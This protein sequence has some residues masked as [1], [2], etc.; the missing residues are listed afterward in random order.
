MFHVDPLAV[1]AQHAALQFVTLAGTKIAAEL[2]SDIADDGPRTV[3]QR[4]PDST[5]AQHKIHATDIGQGEVTA[6]VDATV[7]V[8]VV[9]QYGE[10]QARG[11]EQARATAP[12]ASDKSRS[13]ETK[14]TWSEFLARK[15][16][17][18]CFQ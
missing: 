5:R 14:D 10:L 3:T 12:A 9:R 7:E 17:D 2:G 8:Q 18:V 13:G 1:S 15:D 16:G 11:I 4:D 6:V